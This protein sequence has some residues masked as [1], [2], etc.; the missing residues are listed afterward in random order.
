MDHKQLQFKAESIDTE[1]GIFSG[2]A[3]TSDLDQGGDIIVKGA[4]GRTLMERKERVKVLWQHDMDKP[5]GKPTLLEERDGGLYIEAQL[6]MT[7]LGRDAAILL[8]DGVIDSM[9]IG[10]SVKEKDYDAD[11]IRIIKDLDL[12]EVSLVSF[13]MNEKAVI[14][15]VK[16]L[17]VK[18][19]ERV[20]REAG[21]S[22]S[23]AKKVA[24]SGVGSLR[25]AENQQPEQNLAELKEALLN[26]TNT[27]NN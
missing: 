19:I 7:T 21:L 11:G 5:I 24:S 18:E 9:S 2:F 17:E 13:P 12:F 6:S 15:S 4:F 1:K 3:S 10:Y 25:E 22:R 20:L 16:S 23:Q 8:K 26:L 14:T 27:L